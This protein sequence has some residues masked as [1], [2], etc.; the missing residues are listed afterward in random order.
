MSV[1]HS[2]TPAASTPIE[3]IVEAF[4]GRGLNITWLVQTI[5]EEVNDGGTD[6]W[7]TLVSPII[8]DQ[9]VWTS[10]VIAVAV[11]LVLSIAT[12][13]I[14]LLMRCC[15][16]GVCCCACCA[17]AT[18][19]VASGR[20]SLGWYA[21]ALA[22]A[23]AA[24]VVSVLNATSAIEGATAAA[25]EA[26]HLANQSSALVNEVF[27]PIASLAGD[28]AEGEAAISSAAQL[29][30]SASTLLEQMVSLAT[31]TRVRL[32]AFPAEATSLPAPTA[33]YSEAQR[34]NFEQLFENE[35]APTLSK[36]TEMRA[37]LQSALSSMQ[38][39]ASELDTALVELRDVNA[40]LADAES[41]RAGT[42]ACRH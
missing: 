38:S 30:S 36:V 32:T 9:I 39:A 35:L 33:K 6:I 16:P 17:P 5:T 27:D 40:S 3:S 22:G 18:S 34:D 23:V 13:L 8:S 21:L 15:C 12:C 19:G 1:C 10:S 28:V 4:R 26:S 31:L 20:W 7:N 29:V 41:P 37:T 25:C 42:C 24:T 14:F 11:L 2:L